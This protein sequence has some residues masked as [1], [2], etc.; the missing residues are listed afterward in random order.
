MIHTMRKKSLVIGGTGDS[1]SICK[2]PV[3]V[4]GKFL[5]LGRIKDEELFEI[6]DPED[7]INA[8][9][10]AGQCK[11]DIFTF[12]QALPETK[13]KYDYPMEW[14]P[15]AAINI[16]SYEHWL[17]NQISSETRNKIRK[18][19]KKGIEV[20]RVEFN[21]ELVEGIMD[22]F[23]ETPIRRGVPFWHYGKDF[24]TVKEEWSRDLEKSDFIGAYYKKKLIGYIK[25]IYTP[26]YV[27]VVQ[28]ISKLEHR[29]KYPNNAMIA[30][31]IEIC[32]EKKIPF[33]MY[34]GV[35][36]RGNHG[37]FQRRIGFER[38][39]LPRYYVPMNFK[40]R[41]AL[42]LKLHH[43]IRGILP[44]V[45]VDRLIDLRT[46]WYTFQYSKVLNKPK[47]A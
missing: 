27:D 32:G 16:T 8:L 22:I 29:D 38:V 6:E 25:Q 28:F 14:E 4:T 26:N 13:P 11:P 15:I 47:N 9:S 20:K 2:H 39:L 30:K 35:Y 34:T 3:L 23:N 40:G 19:L 24:E 46:R 37:E 12:R 36:R 21:D 43:G 1:S 45:V 7:I 5:K 44:E 18:S 17:K 41:T 42:L 10:N 33:L 31:A